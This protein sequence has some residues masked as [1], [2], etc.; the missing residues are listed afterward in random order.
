MFAILLAPIITLLFQRS[1]DT[2]AIPDVWKTANV[3]PLFKKCEK[4]LPANYRPISL[5]CI[6]CKVLE[7][8][9]STN[10]VSHLDRHNILYDLQHG[11]RAKRSCETQLVMLVEDLARGCT[12][13]KQT[14]L[15]LLDFS[16]AFDNVIE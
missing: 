8:I 11:F 16:K 14:D 4:S 1:L 3:T 15:I 13:G 12:D 2:G 9:V 10:L 5:T 6:L 7:H